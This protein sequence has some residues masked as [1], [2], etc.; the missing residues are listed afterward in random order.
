MSSKRGVAQNDPQGRAT[1]RGGQR[2]LAK[3]TGVE[4]R[5]VL[6]LSPSSSL[7]AHDSLIAL[8]CCP[9]KRVV[10]ME[11]SVINLKNKISKAD[12]LQAIN[13][14]S[15]KRFKSL[16]ACWQAPLG[17]FVINY[18]K[19]KCVIF[20]LSFLKSTKIQSSV[21]TTW[22]EEYIRLSFV[23]ELA[24]TLDATIYTNS[25]RETHNP[26]PE[27]YTTLLAFYKSKFK[28]D[29]KLLAIAKQKYI[30]LIK[31]PTIVPLINELEDKYFSMI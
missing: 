7:P 23:E 1:L 25:T 29:K 18:I 27:K 6:G 4:S 8:N 15:E 5:R 12:F 11:Y 26:E 30:D 21:T 19:N 17:P 31:D 24:A 2:K 10:N 3:S 22:W 16:L 28:H 20:S 9:Y 14:V 13:Y